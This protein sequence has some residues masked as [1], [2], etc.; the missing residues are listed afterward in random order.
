MAK[1]RRKKS[2]DIANG[3]RLVMDDDAREGR[4]R[5]KS[6]V[7]V[8]KKD[9]DKGPEA[10]WRPG[11]E[12]FDTLLTQA[13]ET[14]PMRKTTAARRT[15]NVQMLF[16]LKRID[17]RMYDAACAFR[18]DFDRAGFVGIRAASLLRVGGG[19][20]CDLPAG[21]DNRSKIGRALQHLGGLGGALTTVAWH[22]IGLDMPMRKTG[23][24]A[25]HLRVSMVDAIS[26]IA[27]VYR[28][29]KRLL[30]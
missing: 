18:E 3:K 17:R 21:I 24:T 2:K 20:A 25:I 23:S 10:V 8:A 5:D 4:Y 9:D 26:K 6:G 11:H 14:A 27:E 12:D 19:G 7:S 29:E 1:K 13:I 30:R 16:D 15:N 28:P 22:Y